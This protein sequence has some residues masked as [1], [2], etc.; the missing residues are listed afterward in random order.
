MNVR[1]LIAAAKT[2]VMTDSRIAELKAL[3]I[4]TERKY[5]DQA[6]RR[7][8]TQEALDRTYTI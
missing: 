7:E 6:A 5:E 1:E 3:I 2:S 8:V 4:E